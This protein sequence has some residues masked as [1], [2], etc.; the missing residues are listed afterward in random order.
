MDMKM[1]TIDF[2]SLNRLLNKRNGIIPHRRH[3]EAF[4]AK[5]NTQLDNVQVKQT[6]IVIIRYLNGL[7]SK[8][9]KVRNI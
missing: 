8:E 7:N 6:N 4:L 2:N 1:K 5:R 3:A 9:L